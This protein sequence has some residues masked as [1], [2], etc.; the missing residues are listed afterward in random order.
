MWLNINL[1]NNLISNIYCL[2]SV[3]IFRKMEGF[4]SERQLPDMAHI[5]EN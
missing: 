2:N 3:E 1:F 5:P 4:F